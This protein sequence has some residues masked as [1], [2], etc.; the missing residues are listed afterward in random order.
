MRST[1]LDREARDAAATATWNAESAKPVRERQYFLFGEIADALARTPGRLEVDVAERGRILLDLADRTCRGEFN[2]SDDSEVVTLIGEPP[3]FVPIAPVRAGGFLANPEALIFRRDACRRYVQ[4]SSLDGAPRVLTAGFPEQ[5]SGMQSSRGDATRPNTGKLMPD[6][7]AAL[8]TPIPG[9][10][11][12]PGEAEGYTLLWDA[13]A[14]MSRANGQSL[15]RNWLRLMDAFWRGDLAPDGLT[16]F[17]PAPPAGRECV[18]LDRTALGGMLLG[19]RAL[20]TKA[21]SIDDLRHWRVSDY[22]DQPAPFGAYFEHDPE[23]RVGLAL[24]TRELALARR[25]KNF[26]IGGSRTRGRCS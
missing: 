19:H 25:R 1:R 6:D 13:A 16:Y 15:A 23:G 8:L 17:Y 2:L 14:E 3:Y 9:H 5:A 22:R 26:G 18:V 10:V 21:A 11:R 4:N 7:R 24:P 20:D 12:P